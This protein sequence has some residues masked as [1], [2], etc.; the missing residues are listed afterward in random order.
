MPGAWQAA[1]GQMWLLE[2]RLP[3]QRLLLYLILV[4]GSLHSQAC[5]LP[6]AELLHWFGSPIASQ[7]GC[8]RL[9]LLLWM[10]TQS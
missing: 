9:R 2:E 5:L 4:F 8:C 6:S 7:T 10:L 3:A 1:M